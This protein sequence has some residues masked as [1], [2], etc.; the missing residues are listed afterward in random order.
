MEMLDLIA[1]IIICLFV[2]RLVR[3]A[4]GFILKRYTVSDWIRVYKIVTPLF[5]GDLIFLFIVVLSIRY[6]IL[7]EV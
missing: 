5:W 1:V 6:L 2:M 7:N 4:Q 3:L